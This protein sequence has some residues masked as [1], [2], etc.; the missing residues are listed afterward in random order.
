MTGKILVMII[1]LSTLIFGVGLYYTQVYAFYE[2]ITAESSGGVTLV[3][4]ADGVTQEL[5]HHDFKGIDSVSSPIRYRACYSLMQSLDVL[6]ESYQTYPKAVPLTSPKWFDCF[7]AT[8]IGE[9]L[10]AGT[11]KAFLGVSNVMY[12]IDRVVAVMPDG[13]AFAWHQ[14]N[15]CGKLAFDGDPVPAHCP[16]KPEGQ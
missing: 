11:A 14:I 3:A 12:G 1:V 7:D 8:E 4:Q 9:A 16:P 6:Q 15:D 5:K 2:E 13:R 10:E